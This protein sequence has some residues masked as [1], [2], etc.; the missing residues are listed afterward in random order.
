MKIGSIWQRYLFREILK[1]F[2]LFLG[3]FFFLYSLMDYSLHM[4]DFLVDKQI[5]LTHLFI[6]YFYQFIKRADLL[7]PLALLIATLKVLFSFNARGELVALQA[8]GLSSKK[9]LR[10]FF[11]LALFCTL[12]NALSMEFLLPSSLNFL[13]RFRESHF[14]HMSSGRKE[15]IHVIHLKDRSKIVYQKEDQEKQLYFDVFWIRTAD[16]I[17]RMKYLSTNPDQPMGYFVDHIICS[18][19]GSFEKTA[20]FEQMAFPS[21]RLQPDPTGKGY[22]PIENRKPSELFRMLAHKRA[23]TA[24]EYPQA[25]THL[26]HKCMMPLL[27]FLVIIAAAPFCFRHSR[28]LPVFFTYAIALFA[29]IAFTAYLDSALILGETQVLSAYNAILL[30][31]ALCFAG[32]GWKFFKTR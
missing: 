17:W 2:F 32:F 10:P 18:P 21:F 15:P 28:S 13:D 9:I 29:F 7:I 19:E 22:I 3:C 20:S 8:S 30:P 5:H 14:K 23:T 11:L 31:F 6:Y 24:F 1:V 12:F 26:L 27:S 16:D 25:L 4:Q